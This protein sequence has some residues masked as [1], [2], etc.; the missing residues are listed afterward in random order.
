MLTLATRLIDGGP[1]RGVHR[2]VRGNEACADRGEALR[3]LDVARVVGRW[4][5]KP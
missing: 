4:P 5:P 1:G 3:L 2:V